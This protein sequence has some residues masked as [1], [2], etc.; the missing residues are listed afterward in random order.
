M[1]VNF[2]GNLIWTNGD[3]LGSIISRDI[4]KSKV[5]FQ[6]IT[7]IFLRINCDFGFYSPLIRVMPPSITGLCLHIRKHYLI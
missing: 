6:K 2:G 5:V 7:E 1:R 4:W 3:L